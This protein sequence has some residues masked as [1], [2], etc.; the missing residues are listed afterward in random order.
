MFSKIRKKQFSIVLIAVM[1]M[2][3]LTPMADTVRAAA[4][5]N[6]AISVEDAI[7]KNNDGSEATV[8]GYI[9]GYVISPENVTRTDFREDHNVA[10]ADEPGETDIDKMLYVQVSSQYRADFG[11]ATNPTNLDK[12]IVV[13]GDLEQYHLHNGLKNPSAMN[14]SSDE[15]GEP[16]ELITIEEARD[17]GTGT[18]KTKG[19]VTATLKNTIQI[20]DET[21]AIAVRPTSLDVELGDEI[22]VTGQLQDYRGLLQLDGATLDENAG[23]Q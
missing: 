11:L 15:P 14:F 1:V 2:S 23:N 9:V 12:Q 22:T 21:A 10:I 19:I 6:D 20:Q 18:A 8:E 4:A 13:T 5:T 16:I 17:H 3:L 7:A